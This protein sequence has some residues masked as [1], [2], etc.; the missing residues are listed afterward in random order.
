MWFSCYYKVREIIL[1]P[2]RLSNDVGGGRLVISIQAM[3][4][5]YT[6]ILYVSVVSRLLLWREGRGEEV[7]QNLTSL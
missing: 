5:S 7:S 6:N 4:S 1:T 2:P 3:F